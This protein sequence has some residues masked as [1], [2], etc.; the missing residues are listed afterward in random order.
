ME[1]IRKNRI[2]AIDILKVFA[3]LAVLNSHMEACYGDYKYLSTGGAIGDALFFFCSGFMLFRSKVLRFD[4]FVKKKITRIYPTVFVIALVTC[5]FFNNNQ[6]IERI[7]LNGGGW[8]VNCIM[9]YFII[10]WF[11]QKFL[12]NRLGIVCGVLAIIII[13][14]YYPFLNSEPGFSIYG[15]TYYKWIFFFVFM[16]Q[17]AIIGMNIDKYKYSK[18]SLPIMILCIV[19]WYGILLTNQKSGCFSEYIYISLI[20]L[21][22][23]TYYGYKFCCAPFWSKIYN[24][25]IVGQILYIAG[26]LCLE[27][28]LIQFY[29]F[30]DYFNFIFPLNIPLMMLV[31]LIVSY[32]INFM[33]NVLLQTLQKGNYE[34]NKTF[35]MRR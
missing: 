8:F 5:I 22:G 27:C 12:L 16:L 14:T 21:L 9:I 20:P 28:Y 15:N 2:V 7:L 11:I 19:S 29:L 33:T 32:V 25:N 23:I 31:V 6:N 13:V 1:L 10:M 26:N 35:L 17:G 3:V 30:T 34:W 24:T 18:K 4:N